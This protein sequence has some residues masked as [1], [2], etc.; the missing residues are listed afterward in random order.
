MK[1]T[2]ASLVVLALLL[3][4]SPPSPAADPAPPPSIQDV[5]DQGRAAFFRNDLATA[6][7]LLTRVNQADPRHRP[8]VIMLKNIAMAEKEAATKAN[9]LEARLR[10]TTLPRLD[11]ADTRL[12]DALEFIQLKAAAVSA[13][14]H[15]PNFVIRL[16]E[17]DLRRPVTLQ[18]SKP[19]LHTALAAV[20]TLADLD[21]IYE[22]HTVTIRSRR[23]APATAAKP[24]PSEIPAGLPQPR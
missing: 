8:T 6:K 14:G 18:L 3:G 22:S 15:K 21:I 4:T 10:R 11:L 20:A 9:S 16:T 19:S 13:D 1:P 17:E 24:A 5:Y 12:P 23:L 2:A 7:R